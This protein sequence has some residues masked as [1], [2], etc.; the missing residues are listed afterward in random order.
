MAKRVRRQA[1]ACHSKD[2]Y[3]SPK[4]GQ[5]VSNSALSLRWN[6]D[7]ID[8]GT[9]DVYL[10]SQH[11]STSL[12]V[13]AWLGLSTDDGAKSVPL[14]A[15]WW[16]HTQNMVVNLQFVPGGSQPWESPYPLSPS[17]TLGDTG[18]SN[19]GIDASVVSSNNDVTRY[20]TPDNLSLGKLAAAVVLPILALIA[21][22]VGGFLWQ[23]KRQARREAE[24][25]ER[26]LSY[27]QSTISPP[28]VYTHTPE[29]VAPT[30][31]PAPVSYV[32]MQP[33]SPKEHGMDSIT[34]SVQDSSDI[35]EAPAPPP[36]TEKR[37]TRPK[38]KRSTYSTSTQQC[39]TPWLEDPYL[40]PEDN[41]PAPLAQTD[42]Q[43]WAH[44]SPRIKDAGGDING[45]P[46]PAQA[47]G[48][49]LTTA[50]GL[51]FPAQAHDTEEEQGPYTFEPQENLGT[52]PHALGTH[53]RDERIYAYLSKL[54]EA[55]DA[56]DTD[57]GIARPS[58]AASW[59]SHGSQGFHDAQAYVDDS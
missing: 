4:P 11:Q 26:S 16:N 9:F 27:A 15:Q 12:P 6:A 30:W 23:R 35:P 19:M 41:L 33:E 31:D 32:D 14:Q 3:R 42:E 5:V 20:A 34:S 7:C 22:L 36:S 57:R 55:N 25:R 10:Y 21:V 37:R 47:R 53:S 52:T 45:L 1:A 51:T 13:H 59:L 2:L 56:S 54:Q 28:A 44:R 46:Q 40:L 49:D 48:A 43:R 24:R 38:A 58:S 18:D 29:T 17:W 8:S 39:P 50:L